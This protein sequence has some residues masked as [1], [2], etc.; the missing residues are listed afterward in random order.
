MIQ[1]LT[2]KTILVLKVFPHSM[3]GVAIPKV[4]TQ[5]H[6]EVV[7]GTVDKLPKDHHRVATAQAPQPRQIHKDLAVIQG[8]EK[9]LQVVPEVAELTLDKKRTRVLEV[10]VVP[11]VEQLIAAQ[12]QEETLVAEVV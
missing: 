9:L 6:L 5:S 4:A 8:S 10:L 12:V 7:A 2:S 11:Q 1:V 3:V